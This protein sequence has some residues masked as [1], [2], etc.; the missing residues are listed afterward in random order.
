[1]S[2]MDIEESSTDKMRF[3]DK[4]PTSETGS[5]DWKDE[6]KSN[7]NNNTKNYYPPDLNPPPSCG[8]HLRDAI[9][10]ILDLPFFQYLGIAVLVGV[11]ASGA[12]FFFFLMGWQTLC[13]PRTDCN[14]RNDIYNVA[15]QFLN[16]FFTYMACVSMPWRCTNFLHTVGWAC[17]PRENAPG[18]DLYGQVTD[19]V[20]FHVPLRQRTVILV[21][22]LLNCLFQFANQ[23]TRIIYYNY[24]LQN[25]FP[26]NMWTNV[27]FGMSMICAA[28]GGGLI[29]WQTGKQR[30][31]DP[32][33]FGPGP[34]ELVR[35]VINKVLKRDQQ[36]EQQ[37]PPSAF[38]ETQIDET[39]TT[40]ATRGLYRASQGSAQFDPT[41]DSMRRSVL[42]SSR[43]SLR[44]FAM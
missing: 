25:E 34:V 5:S 13:R 4:Q 7:N 38:E 36:E 12:V 44:M 30:A 27:F 2:N 10:R 19:D 8:E 32:D 1:M 20:W 22:L 3:A 29:G 39:L 24:E 28:V 9:M 6:P 26:G 33:R 17:P 43:S 11:V 41:R 16:V 35:G 18:H 31:A 14:P 40:P 15:I 23:V 42:G 37:Q 21:F